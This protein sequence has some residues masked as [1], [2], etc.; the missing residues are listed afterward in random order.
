MI[1]HAHLIE[2]DAL[3]K[4]VPRNA[5][6]GKSDFRFWQEENRKILKNLLGVSCPAEDRKLTVEFTKEHDAFTEM[7]FVFQ[8]EENEFVPCHLLVPKIKYE[9]KPPVMICLQGH[10]TGMHI[11]LGRAIFDEDVDTISNGNR[12]FALQCVEKGFCAVTLEQRCFGERGGY[13]HTD[14]HSA[15]LTAMLSGRTV[16]GGR[17]LDVSCLIDVLEQSFGNVCN[18]EKVY[19]MGNS[20]GGTTSFY[21]AALEL[22][23]KAVMPSCAFCT[24]IDSIGSIRH[25]ECNYVPGIAK[26][27]DMAEIAGLI[28]PRPLVIVSGEKDNIFPIEFAKS[29]FSRLKKLYEASGEPEKCRHIIGPEGH[30]FYADLGWK[31]FFELI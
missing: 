31:A 28:A 11:S 29:E 21:A 26:Y 14:C 20:G 1:K 23:I 17:V 30:R 9:E 12:D 19:I 27:F 24:F 10:S 25:C 6:D 16:L 3:K 8:S 15:S 13:P 7:R 22:R 18:A 4:T 5:Y 2:I